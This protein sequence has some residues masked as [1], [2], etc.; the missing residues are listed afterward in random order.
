MPAIDRSLSDCRYCIRPACR[1]RRA[2]DIRRGRRPRISGDNNQS[3]HSTAQSF[4][5][6]HIATVLRQLMAGSIL[7]R[8]LKRRLF[9]G[10]VYF[11]VWFYSDPP[12]FSHCPTVSPPHP[13]RCSR[14]SPYRR[15]PSPSTSKRR[16]QP[17]KMTAQTQ[18]KEATLRI[19]ILRP[20]FSSIFD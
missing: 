12:S 13:N 6:D 10:R 7:L 15:C 16:K 3:L 9:S 8:W 2:G 5:E 4:L 18:M 19:H 17:P 11:D 20:L 14:A 1:R